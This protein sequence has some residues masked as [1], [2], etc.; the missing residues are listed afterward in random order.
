MNKDP[1][2]LVDVLL[3]LQGVAELILHPCT[4]HDPTFPERIYYTPEER[5]AEMAYFE[6]VY[7]LLQERMKSR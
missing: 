7:G 5:H 2:Q 3:T 6:R 1:E 4:A